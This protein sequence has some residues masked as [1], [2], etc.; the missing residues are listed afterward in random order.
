MCCVGSTPK[1]AVSS[2]K[3]LIKSIGSTQELRITLALTKPN[4]IAY[5]T[6]KCCA[7]TSI[8]EVDTINILSVVL[9]EKCGFSNHI[10]YLTIKARQSFYALRILRSH[11]LLGDCL[12]DVVGYYYIRSST[13]GRMLYC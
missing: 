4:G 6:P 13:V 10:K 3:L 11:G 12:F 7:T 8:M 9:T 2:Q 1:V 5:C